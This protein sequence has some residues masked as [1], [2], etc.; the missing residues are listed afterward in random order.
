M[1]TMQTIM[2]NRDEL[3]L[4]VGSTRRFSIPFHG[5]RPQDILFSMAHAV[6]VPLQ[7]LIGVDRH[8]HRKFLITIGSI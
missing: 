6:D 1:N 3:T 4:V 7:L 8:I 2:R 5:T